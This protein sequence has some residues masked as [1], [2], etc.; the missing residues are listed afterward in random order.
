MVFANLEERT[1]Q[2]A[3]QTVFE[4]LGLSAAMESARQVTARIA[5]LVR[6]TVR[7]GHSENNLNYI[8]VAMP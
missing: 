7:G 4:L 5:P 3:K 8:A 6:L 2:I 1:A